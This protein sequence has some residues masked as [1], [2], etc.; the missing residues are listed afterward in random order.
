MKLKIV[1]EGYQSA[2]HFNSKNYNY[3]ENRLVVNNIQ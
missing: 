3:F 2:K 1:V